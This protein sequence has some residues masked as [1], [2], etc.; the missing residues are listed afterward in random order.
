[1]VMRDGI[2]LSADVYGAKPNTRKPALLMR[3]PYDKHGPKAS[4]EHFA[5]AGYAVVVQ[6]TRGAYTSEGKYVHYNN[7]DQDGFDTIEWIARQPWSN[8]KVGM[9]GA[10]HPGEVQWMAAGSRPPSLL[11]IAPTAAASSL[12]HIMYQGGALRLALLAAGAALRVN[13]PPAG[14]APP[15]DFSLIHEHLP[16]STL[17]EAIGWQMPWLQGIIAHNRLDGFWQ[18]T[19][20]TPELGDLELAVQNIVGYYDLSCNEVIDNFQ[21][22]PNHGRKQLILGPWDHGTIGKEVVAGVDFGPQAKLDIDTENLSWFDRFLKSA[23]DAPEFSPVRYFMMGENSWRTST[24][25]PPADAISTAFYLHSGGEA[26]TRTGNGRVTDKRPEMEPADVFE[27]DPERPVPSEP[28]T[29]PEPS[30]GTPWRPVDRAS[31]EDR[32]DVLVYTAAVQKTPL[33]IAGHV[34]ADLW[35]SVDAPDADWALKLIDVAPDGAARGLAEGILRSSG[36]D[37]V[38]YPSLLNPGR[39]YHLRVDLGS[40]AATILAGHALRIEI[41]GS[42]FPMFDRNLHT[43]EGPVGYRKQ[44]ARQTVYHSREFASRFLL[45][46]LH[47]ARPSS[48]QRGA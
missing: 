6:D 32:R 28:A 25:W 17:D 21:K 48:S 36:R 24:Q 29:A 4:A 41:A 40:T 47:R 43:G 42:A 10:S 12:Y 14:T 13:P 22:L 33:S 23:K 1:V 26:N 8:G 16:L 2:H 35:I 19:E 7:D 34:F 11:A 3:T 9:W 5:S 46:V 30:R 18:R 31:I 27:S 38:R 39:R 20:I 45:P 44:V 37:P 15:K